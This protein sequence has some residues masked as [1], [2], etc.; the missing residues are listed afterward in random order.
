VNRRTKEK[1]KKQKK[2]KKRRGF[3]FKCREFFI[4]GELANSNES[5]GHIDNCN[6]HNLE[7]LA[8][9]RDDQKQEEKKNGK[10]LEEKEKPLLLQ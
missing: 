8:Q 1:N 5:F 2:K 4:V 9:K 10:N 7:E 3:Y 6:A